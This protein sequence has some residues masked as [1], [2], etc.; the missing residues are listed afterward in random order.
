[1]IS[2]RIKE[3]VIAKEETIIYNI[4]PVVPTAYIEKPPF[5]IRIKEHA[6]IS[7]VVRKSNIKAPK[8]SE[9]IKVEPNVAMVKDLLVENVDGHVIYFCDE[10]ARIAKPDEKD[11]HIPVVGMHYYRM[12][13]RQH[14]HQRPFDETVCDPS[15]TNG[16][17]QAPP[18]VTKTVRDRGSIKYDLENI[19]VWI[20]GRQLT[21]K[22][23]L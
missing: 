10:A 21:F 6:N 23:C 9:K 1:M 11:K 20:Y 3:P 7:T 13:Q 5:P 16:I 2:L 18:P 12:V 15:I 19:C 8:P 17:V 4:D 22:N 14:S